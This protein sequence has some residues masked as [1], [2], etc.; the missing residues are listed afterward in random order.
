M[1][2]PEGVAKALRGPLLEKFPAALLGRLVVIPYFPLDDAV[3]GNIV[4]LQLERITK[5][6]REHH[7]IPF[8]YDEE[9]VKLIVS[10]CTEVESGGRTIDA[11][12]TNTVLPRFY[13]KSSTAYRFR[14]QV[15]YFLN[16]A[17]SSVPLQQ[18]SMRMS[19]HVCLAI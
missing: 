8:S 15:R 10:R 3:L 11:I 19:C 12:L 18:R 7:K 4:E 14:Y 13:E 5:R 16:S 17:N 9:A 2:E 6:V 1:P